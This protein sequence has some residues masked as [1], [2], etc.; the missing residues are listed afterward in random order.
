MQKERSLDGDLSSVNQVFN[1]ITITSG[2]FNMNGDVD[3]SKVH[4]FSYLVA[5]PN[6]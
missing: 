3:Y 2:N 6:D 4:I 1:L 5:G